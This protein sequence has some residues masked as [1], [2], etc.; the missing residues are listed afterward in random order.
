[1]K[2]ISMRK[3]SHKQLQRG[4]LIS[5]LEHALHRHDNNI[6]R[7]HVNPV[8]LDYYIFVHDL[9]R[10]RRVVGNWRRQILD[11]SVAETLCV[12][13][14]DDNAHPVGSQVTTDGAVDFLERELRELVAHVSIRVG[15]AIVAAIQRIAELRNLRLRQDVAVFHQKLSRCFESLAKETVENKLIVFIKS[16]TQR[17]QPVLRLNRTNP[18]LENLLFPTK[19]RIPQNSTLTF[20]K[21]GN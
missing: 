7:L 5:L 8:D 3:F 16:C 12:F 14:D 10:F 17:K 21:V 11:K 18:D 13:G 2:D 4:S 6:F 20:T 1:M 19:T 9:F 15:Y